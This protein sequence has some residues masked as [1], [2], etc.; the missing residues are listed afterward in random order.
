[1][2]CVAIAGL[3]LR[4]RL[5]TWMVLYIVLRSLLLATVEA[6]EARYTLEFFPIF[7]VLG[8]IAVGRVHAAVTSHNSSAARVPWLRWPR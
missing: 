6:P 3:C 7:F 4:P 2:S 1:M 5:W 8:G